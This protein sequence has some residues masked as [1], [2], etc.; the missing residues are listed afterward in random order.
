MKTACAFT[1]I[2]LLVVIAIIAILA[3]ML[4]P[5]LSSA[6]QHAL[7]INCLGNVKQLT[8]ASF[9]Y[10]TDNSALAAYYPADDTNGLW[11]GMGYYGNQKQLLR[12]P[13]THDPQPRSS[14]LGGAAD[15]TWSWHGDP[16]SQ[17]ELYVGSYA[18]NSWLY[19]KATY[20]GADHPEFM[21]SKPSMI[22]NPSQTPVF[23]DAVWVGLWPLESDPPAHDLYDGDISQAGMATCTIARHGGVNPAR[24]PR[25]FDT[26]QPL[27]GATNIGLAD[28]H[29]DLSKLENLWQWYWHRNWAPP[30]TRPQ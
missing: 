28:G 2:E 10:A 23:L 9:A 27:S 6:K 4:M 22:Q 11:M 18:F 15:L 8:L 1:L 29:A 19:D 25:D 24:A 3:A 26:S 14:W 16:A 20:R 7:Q 17:F 13:S 12:C 30:P 21:M 5:A